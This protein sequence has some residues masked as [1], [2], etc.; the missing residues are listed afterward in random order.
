MKLFPATDLRHTSLEKILKPAGIENPAF[1]G[2]LQLLKYEDIAAPSENSSYKSLRDVKPSWGNKGRAGLILSVED[3]YKLDIAL[4]ENEI[5]SSGTIKEMLSP[6]IRNTSGSNY[7]YGFTIEN[8]I[9]GTKV[10][11]HSGDDDGI[12]HNVEYLDFPEENVK[13]LIASNSN[14]YSGTSWSSVISA[15]IQRILFSSDYTYQSG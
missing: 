13:I 5:L 11:G 10:F 9:R 1:A 2:N 6:K 8:T 12:G 7:G 3:L 14:L 15:Q 4:N